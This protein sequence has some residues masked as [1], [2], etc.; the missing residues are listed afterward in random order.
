MAAA[1]SVPVAVGGALLFFVFLVLLGLGGWRWLQKHF[2]FHRS[3]DTATSGFDNILFNVVGTPRCGQVG[4]SVSMLNDG[5]AVGG[6]DSRRGTL[7]YL[8]RSR[9]PFNG[10]CPIFLLLP[11]IKLPS[12]NPSPAA[13][14]PDKAW[15]LVP[16]PIAFSPQMPNLLHLGLDVGIGSCLA[17]TALPP[18]GDFALWCDQG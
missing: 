7:P 14:Q 3:M 4:D 11:R 9:L 5:K 17:S 8:S 18:S 10:S 6:L 13:H 15:P 1:V 2:P 16:T 12:Q